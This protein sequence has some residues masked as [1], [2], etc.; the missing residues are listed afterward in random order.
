MGLTRPGWVT[1]LPACTEITWSIHAKAESKVNEPHID[2][3]YPNHFAQVATRLAERR[4][5][6][7]QVTDNTRKLLCTDP[8]NPGLLSSLHS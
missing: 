1:D 2:W 6:E 5:Q 8:N 4:A 3:I 7:L